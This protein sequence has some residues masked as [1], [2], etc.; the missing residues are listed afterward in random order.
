[1]WAGLHG[2][3]S[4]LRENLWGFRLCGARRRD[5]E[6]RW[7][8]IC[9]PIFVPAYRR[10]DAASFDGGSR[11]REAVWIRVAFPFGCVV[12]RLGCRLG[13]GAL[14]IGTPSPVAPLALFTPPQKP[15]TPPTTHPTKEPTKEPT[16]EP[17]KEPTLVS[18]PRSPATT[19]SSTSTSSSP[20]STH[21]L[22]LCTNPNPHKQ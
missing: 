15:P 11:A 16:N 17:T 9:D 18:P 4:N 19:T 5:L 14:R 8:L 20:S 10:S 21:P 13:V 2:H 3:R 7:V 12:G 1:M 22:P 6:L